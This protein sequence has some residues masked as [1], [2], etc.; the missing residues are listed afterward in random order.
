VALG[1]WP[2]QGGAPI[3]AIYITNKKRKH[4]SEPFNSNTLVAY[5][6]MH[7]NGAGC[8]KLKNR[9]VGLAM[10]VPEL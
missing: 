10:N 5:I 4:Y 7:K 2:M 8:S 9:K 1:T 3:K 6:Y